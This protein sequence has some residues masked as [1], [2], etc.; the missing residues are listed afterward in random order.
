MKRVTIMATLALVAGAV[1]WD[2]MEFAGGY[3]AFPMVAAFLPVS[4]FMFALTA[5]ATCVAVVV[6]LMALFRRRFAYTMILAL[7]IAACWLILP[8]FAGRSLFL[9]GLST[10]LHQLSSPV[11]IQSVARTCHFLMPSGGMVFGPRKVM[12]PL[13]EEAE[14]N[15]RV[16]SA[17]SSHPFVHLD[18]DTGVVFVQ[19]SKVSFIWGGALPGHWGILVGAPS[20]Q[21]SSF[22]HQTFRFADGIVLFRGE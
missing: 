12:G 17:I 21:S 6:S 3:N 22:Y 20:G 1:G 19:A 2:A 10:R 4:F 15:Q 11:E 14:Q 8:W 7:T 13:P 9:L 5:V 18:G 16:W